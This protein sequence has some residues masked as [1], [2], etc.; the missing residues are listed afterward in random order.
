[1]AAWGTAKI[2]AHSP[3]SF[4]GSMRDLLRPPV[5]QP[6]LIERGR[7]WLLAVAIAIAVLPGPAHAEET[8]DKATAKRCFKC[9]GEDGL[10][11]SGGEPIIAGHPYPYIIGSLLLFQKEER[12]SK[13][14]KKATKDLSRDDMEAVARYYAS[15]P[16]KPPAKPFDPVLAQRGAKFHARWCETCHQEGG[17]R[18]KMEDR[19]GPLLAGQTAEYL[20]AQFGLFMT[21]DREMPTD[22]GI[23]MLELRPG[24]ANALVH[25]YVSNA[26]PR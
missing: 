21:L 10:D 26:A 8:G 5:V 15:L 18:F 7:Q 2:D 4:S 19:A 3:G 24:D 12:I 16:S 25:Y 13:A 22:M 23:A 1:M 6:R 17:R 9:H 11:S 20:R 14:M